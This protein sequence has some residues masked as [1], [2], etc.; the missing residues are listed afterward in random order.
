[1]IHSVLFGSF[2][3]CPFLKGDFWSQGWELTNHG[4][5]ATCN[6]HVEVARIDQN[7]EL[8][9]QHGVWGVFLDRFFWRGA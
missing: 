7:T 6:L 8:P 1:M 4:I 5:A 3:I 2:I 9:H